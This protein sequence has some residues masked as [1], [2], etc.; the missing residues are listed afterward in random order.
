MYYDIWYFGHW[1]YRYPLAQAT[2]H[3]SSARTFDHFTLKPSLGINRFVCS[4][5]VRTVLSGQTET[6][7]VLSELIKLIHINYATQAR[8]RG[9]YFCC[10]EDTSTGL[11]NYPNGEKI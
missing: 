6:N 7:V 5:K 3:S 1:N 2:V 10:C 9:L 8:T 4:K 11:K